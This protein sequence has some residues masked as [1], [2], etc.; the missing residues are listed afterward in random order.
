MFCCHSRLVLQQWR[1]YMKGKGI[2]FNFWHLFYKRV[3][4]CNCDYRPYSAVKLIISIPLPMTNCLE[5]SFYNTTVRLFSHLGST[6][7]NIYVLF[8]YLVFIFSFV[9]SSATQNRRFSEG[10]KYLS[11]MFQICAPAH[12]SILRLN[13]PSFLQSVSQSIRP[14]VRPSVQQS[15]CL[16][17][18]LPTLLLVYLPVCWPAVCL[19]VCLTI[20]NQWVLDDRV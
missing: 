9:P 14:S 8:L 19:L 13:Y 7:V 20:C 1:I 12:Q 11:V 3:K 4:F 15:I 16:L 17:V 10:M 2:S 18:Y 5:T 6:V